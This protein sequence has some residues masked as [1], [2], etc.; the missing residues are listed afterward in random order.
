MIKILGKFIPR[1]K[2]KLA[3]LVFVPS[4][5]YKVYRDVHQRKNNLDMEY[6][7]RNS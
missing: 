7:G 6:V 3:T 4:L 1:H 5:A 2:F